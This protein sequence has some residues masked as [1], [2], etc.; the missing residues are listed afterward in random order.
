MGELRAVGGGTTARNEPGAA[1]AKSL[2][3]MVG[4]GCYTEDTKTKKNWRSNIFHSNT[5]V[6][7]RASIFMYPCVRG[8]KQGITLPGVKMALPT[9]A[10][11]CG[12]AQRACAQRRKNRTHLRAERRGPALGRARRA[13]SSAKRRPFPPEI[14]WDSS[15]SERFSVHHH[16]KNE[17]SG[18]RTHL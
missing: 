11:K 14:L 9:T 8:G 18:S 6:V 12:L 17:K 3:D 4:V 2:S 13:P 16:S 5:S 10:L 15:A 1:V 7:G